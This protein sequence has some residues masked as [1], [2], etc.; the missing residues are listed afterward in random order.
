MTLTAV[1]INSFGFTSRFSDPA[2]IVN[3]NNAHTADTDGDLRIELSELLRLI[4]FYNT[5]SI[6]CASPIGSTEDG[7]TPTEGSIDCA[8]HPSDYAPQDWVIGLSELLRAIQIF[9]IG[10]YLECGPGNEPT[11]DGYCTIIALP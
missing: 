7:Y 6:A 1:A 11:E 2:E 10:A 4:Q 3:L 5:G 9:N 8:P